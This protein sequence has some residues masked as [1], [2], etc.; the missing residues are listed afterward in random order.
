MKLIN[1]K[2]ITSILAVIAI[3]AVA[4]AYAGEKGCLA[5]HGDTEGLVSD[6]GVPFLGKIPFD[7]HFSR[8]CDRG[9]PL[10]EGHF[11]A[12]RFSEISGV[13]TKLLRS[14]ESE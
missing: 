10:E 13:I 5:C 1:G 7:R 3:F 8:C 12:G 4:D 11:I 9:E 2:G 6:S 14:L